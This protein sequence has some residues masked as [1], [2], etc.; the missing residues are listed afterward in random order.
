MRL[1]AGCCLRERALRQHGGTCHLP[2]CRA[3]AARVQRGT[4]PKAQHVQRQH[5]SRSPRRAG[6]QGGGR[7]A[8]VAGRAAVPQQGHRVQGH[9]GSTGMRAPPR[10]PPATHRRVYDGH[11]H[12][13]GRQDVAQR[14]AVRVVAVHGQALHGHVQVQ[15]RLHA[16]RGGGHTYGRGVAPMVRC[17]GWPRGRHRRPGR[18]CCS[19]AAVGPWGRAMPWGRGAEVPIPQQTTRCGLDAAA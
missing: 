11:A 10:T 7:T 3:H 14:L 4:C 12:A 8:C 9:S 16:S 15:G 6:R 2:G 1:L 18:Q 5:P 19:R 13:H 17:G